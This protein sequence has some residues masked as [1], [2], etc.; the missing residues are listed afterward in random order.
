MQESFTSGE[1][2]PLLHARVDLARYMTGLAELK[3]F[4]VLPQ[5]GVTRRPGLEKVSAS[6]TSQAK[7]IPFEYNS[8]DTVLLQF[9][10][11]T[12]TIWGN[13]SGELTI[14]TQIRTEYNIDDVKNLRYVQ[15]GNVVFLAHRKY[16]PKILTRKSLTEWELKDLTT[17]GGPLINSV[18]FANGAVLKVMLLLENSVEIIS[19]EMT[20]DKK[21]EGSLIKFE[22]PVPA[23]TFVF[24]SLAYPKIAET[25]SFFVKGTLNITTAGSKWQGVI[26]IDRSADGGE[27]WTTIRQYRRRDTNTQGQWD[28]TV[29]ETEDYV[30]YKIR[31]YHFEPETTSSQ[32]TITTPNIIQASLYDSLVAPVNNNT[33]SDYAIDITVTASGFLR[34]ETHEI[35]SISS[36]GRT[37]ITDIQQN[38]TFPIYSMLTIGTKITL[39]SIG[40]WGNLQGYPG[41]VAMYQDRLVFASTDR[42]PQTIWLSKT[43]DYSNFSISDPLADDDAVTITLA[44]SSADG[45][46]SLVS[47]GDLLA[48]TTSGEWK[49]SGAGDNGAITPSALTAHQQS[50]IGSKNLQPI[51]VNG[52]IIFV[53]TQGQKVFAL[54]YDLNIDGYTGS[55]LSILSSHIFENKN[56]ISMAYQKIPDSLLWFVLNDGTFVSCT[57]NPEHEVIGW[58]RHSSNFNIKSIVSVSGEKQTEIFFKTSKEILKLKSRNDKTALYSDDSNN[59][60]S[61]LRTLRLNINLEDGS[62]FTK[63]KLIPRLVVSTLNSK[64]AWAAPGGFDD[65]AKNWERRRKIEFYNADF[66]TDTEIQLDNGFDEYAC[67]QIRSI[68]ENPLTIAAITPQITLGG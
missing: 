61:I 25:E 35:K 57:Y 49:I 44:G 43:G 16:K 54:G 4:I 1:I 18:D 19:D 42:Q 62:A 48:F 45:I 37:L 9:S 8:T 14:L 2:S 60:E 66:L 28:F 26:S 55:E 58:A 30:L 59:Y 13:L 5:G 52:R 11:L 65:D 3:N 27:T 50:N 51:L 64:E 41:A 46:H 68:G 17:V 34:S 24:N 40:A 31:A 22:F 29:S 23:K 15:S 36:D 63:K 33:S 47:S 39:W 53:Q 10:N 32:A 7:I 56:I 6:W 20:F 12:L 67:V 38:F 21:L